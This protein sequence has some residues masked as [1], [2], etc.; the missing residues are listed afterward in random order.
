M[1]KPTLPTRATP[2]KREAGALP[3][4]KAL[5]SPQ[6]LIHIGAGTG[7]GTLHQWHTWGVA[8]ALVV[9]A[10]AERL[11]WAEQLATNN[12]G[13]QVRGQIVAGTDGPVTYHQASNPAEDGLIPAQELSA[14]WPNMR[15]AGQEQRPAQRLD[16][17]LAQAGAPTTAHDNTWLLVD[18]LPALPILQ[19]AAA[20]L[21]HCTVVAV[22]AL[23]QPVVG[24]TDGVA[25]TEI[26]TCLLR[27][28]FKCVDTIEGHQPAIGH[29]LF[30]RDWQ[31]ALQQQAQE[32]GAQMRLVTELQ[33]RL[34]E[35]QAQQDNEAQEMSDLTAAHEQLTSDAAKLTV[36]R[37]AEASAKPASLHCKPKL[38]S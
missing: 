30:V 12:P 7:Q 25:L 8:S 24:V 6:T 34:N 27:H 14:I 4:L 1:I 31:A 37:D 9:D 32:C 22:R 38:T 18:C 16:T 33:A 17:L 10:D 21:K 26:D 28:G 36:Q 15:S 5:A 20:T 3:L 11:G 29:A 23:L 2:R 35:L 19:G 13:W